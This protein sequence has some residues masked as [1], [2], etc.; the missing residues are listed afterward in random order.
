MQGIGVAC[1]H[2]GGPRRY[3]EA[4]GEHYIW[5]ALTVS[6]VSCMGKGD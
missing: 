6:G 4:G 2:G 3:V 1:A 5:L